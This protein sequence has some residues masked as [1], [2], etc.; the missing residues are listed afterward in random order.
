MAASPSLALLFD[1]PQ[2]GTSH[3]SGSGRS[4]RVAA[5]ALARLARCFVALSLRR[6]IR[7]CCGLAADAMVARS[8]LPL[9]LSP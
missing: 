7:P 1:R 5:C 9:L 8:T 2:P 6:A 4:Q 3:F